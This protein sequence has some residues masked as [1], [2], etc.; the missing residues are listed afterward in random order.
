MAKRINV[1]P[2]NK[3]RAWKIWQTFEVFVMKKNGFSY[4]L[5]NVG[6]FSKTVE[7]GKTSNYVFEIGTI[8]VH[9]LGKSCG[10]KIE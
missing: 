7:T 8:R 1:G 6:P 2:W 9:F 4:L 10:V 3:R 5:I